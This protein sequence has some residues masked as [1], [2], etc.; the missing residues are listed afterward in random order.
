MGQ[1]LGGS[2]GQILAAQRLHLDEEALQL[3]RDALAALAVALLAARIVG[4]LFSGRSSGPLSSCRA[5]RLL[6]TRA[7]SVDSI[8][9]AW[10]RDCTSGVKSARAIGPRRGIAA[11]HTSL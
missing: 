9:I 7:L 11:G 6:L 4:I 10:V 8:A 2:T 3:I 5:D 1:P